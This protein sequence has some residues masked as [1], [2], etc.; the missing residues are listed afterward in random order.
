MAQK[1]EYSDNL[2]KGTDKL[3]ESIEQSNVA[4]QKAITAEQT[5]NQAKIGRAHV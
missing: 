4:A 5:A 2:K 3:N 1:I